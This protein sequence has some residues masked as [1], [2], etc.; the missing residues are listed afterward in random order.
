MTKETEIPRSRGMEVSADDYVEKPVEP[1]A[2]LASV[3]KLIGE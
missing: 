2:L 3:T 1:D